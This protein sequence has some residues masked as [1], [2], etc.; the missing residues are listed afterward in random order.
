MILA[1]QPALLQATA[2]DRAELSGD[3][4]HNTVVDVLPQGL[5]LLQQ[6]GNQ[7]TVSL[8]G[9]GKVSSAGVA[10]LLEWLREATALNKV[11]YIECLPE[12]MEPI[13]RI[14][15]LEPVF[16]PLLRPAP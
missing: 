14:S 11:L 1:P 2:P 5:A 10:L 4:T 16:G 12:H 9:V 15:D 7:W 13:I 3:L 8:Q 6:A